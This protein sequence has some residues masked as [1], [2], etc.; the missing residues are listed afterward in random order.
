MKGAKRSM[1]RCRKK[2]GWSTGG[3]LGLRFEALGLLGV[4]VDVH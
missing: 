3:D 1:W 2:W 4:E